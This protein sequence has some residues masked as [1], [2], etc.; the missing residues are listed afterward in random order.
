MESSVNPS[1]QVSPRQS[2]LANVHSASLMGVTRLAV[3]SL[4]HVFSVWHATP[5]SVNVSVALGSDPLKQK[6][7]LRPPDVDD[8]AML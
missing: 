4:F 6:C 2:D 8:A 5:A 3:R 1:Q 7:P